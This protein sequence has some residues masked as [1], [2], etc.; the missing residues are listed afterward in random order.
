MLGILYT[1]RRAFRTAGQCLFTSRTLSHDGD[2]QMQ[3]RYA[4]APSQAIGVDAAYGTWADGFKSTGNRL[5]PNAQIVPLSFQTLPSANDRNCPAH[6][7]NPAKHHRPGHA[8]KGLSG[9]G[10][11]GSHAWDSRERKASVGNNLS[12]R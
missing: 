3:R 4:G 12:P 11:A 9:E 7:R 1:D 5:P 8:A 10:W 6:P 2:I